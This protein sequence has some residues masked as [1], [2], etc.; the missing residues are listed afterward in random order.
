MAGIG[1]TLWQWYQASPPALLAL[2]TVIITFGGRYAVNK[3]SDVE[4]E[5][6]KVGDRVDDHEL[7]L[8]YHDDQLKQA[9]EARK[10]NDRRIQQILQQQAAAHGF[11]GRDDMAAQA[12]TAS[13]ADRPGSSDPSD[14]SDRGDSGD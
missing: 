9:R 3:L 4:D 7:L 8:D 2:L 6:D 5:L 12:G 13:A 10:R 14:Q 11:D 1:D